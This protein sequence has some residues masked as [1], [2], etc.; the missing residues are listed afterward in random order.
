MPDQPQESAKQFLERAVN[1]LGLFLHL[2]INKGLSTSGAATFANEALDDCEQAI[3]LDP[4]NA[5]AF[6]L[7]GRT[8]LHLSRYQ[9]ALAASEQAIRLDPND[10]AAF[11]LRAEALA[12]LGRYQEALAA[13]E[14]AIRL[15]PTY[16]EACFLKG[17][18]LTDLRRHQET[19]ASEAVTSEAL[20]ASEQTIRQAPD[21]ADAFFHK[22]KA[23]LSLSRY[24]EAL[25]S[26]ALVASEQAIRL[27][28]NE[29]R[30]Y[31]IKGKALARLGR[32]QEALA[33]FEQA[34]RLHPNSARAY[35]LKSLTLIDLN[36]HQEAFLA[37]EQAI[38]LNPHYPASSPQDTAYPTLKR[39]ARLVVL[40]TGRVFRVTFPTIIVGRESPR[41]L[42]SARR[43]P[44]LF[45][46]LP[47]MKV[48]NRHAYIREQQ[49]TFS[50]E[51][52]NSVH[53]TALNGIILSPDQAYPLNDGD[54]LRFADTE[55]R[56]ELS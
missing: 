32:D 23:L 51:D 31:N 10:G 44:G 13:F 35:Y 29:A 8:L 34:I 6:S 49:G 4:N 54:L 52:H 41:F 53:K 25:A 20:A 1:R 55:V 27:Q 28:P 38:R 39:Q 24:W 45:I 18:A 30:A 12:H 2:G 22:G 43:S 7:K 42:R 26:E 36:R 9:E 14:Q 3:R 17:F 19:L 48:T 47:D 37:Y 15:D 56:F 40:A 46:A 21:T 16:V 11:N 50:I 5:A 33:T